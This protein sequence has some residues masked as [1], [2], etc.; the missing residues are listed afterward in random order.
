MR[1]DH[2]L[3]GIKTARKVVNDH[4]VYIVGNMLGGVA[5]SNDL[6]VGNDYVGVHTK[7]LQPHALNDGA[8]VMA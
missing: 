6:I 2:G 8:K 7:V 3:L 4:V 5:V 1:E